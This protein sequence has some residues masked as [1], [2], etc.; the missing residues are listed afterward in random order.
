M[1]SGLW[2]FNRDCA[3]REMGCELV[4]LSEVPMALMSV[5]AMC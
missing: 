3:S 5:K 4:K 2:F 1:V